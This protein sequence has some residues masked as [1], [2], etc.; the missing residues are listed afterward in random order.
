MK[1]N[2]IIDYTDY[3][4]CWD[5]VKNNFITDC[6]DYTP[7]RDYLKNSFINNCTDYIA[8]RDY[9]KNSFV[10]DCTDYASFRD[11][12]KNN[13]SGKDFKLISFKKF[14]SLCLSYFRKHAPF[15]SPRNNKNFKTCSHMN[16]IITP[17]STKTNFYI[18]Y[19]SIEIPFDDN[20]TIT[21]SFIQ[22]TRILMN[23]MP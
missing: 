2:F 17:R 16:I 23:W 13:F 14:N 11:Y 6:T 7:F 4:N 19:N 21:L 1:C 8:F 5:C 3:A 15:G 20:D 12:V 9:F 10:T 18:N 22:S